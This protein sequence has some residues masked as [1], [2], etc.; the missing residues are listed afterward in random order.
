MARGARWASHAHA[1]AR[2]QLR[3]GGVRADLDEPPHGVDDTGGVTAML[4]LRRAS[5]LER[6]VVMQRWFD[7]HGVAVDVVIGVR[8]DQGDVKAHAWLAGEE[9]ASA[10]RFIEMTRVPPPSAQRTA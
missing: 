6:A 5:C 2:A 3:D 1:S 8:T 9:P 7:A 10:G 4:S